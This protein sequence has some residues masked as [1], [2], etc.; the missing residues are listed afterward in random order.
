MDSSFP[1]SSRL[2]LVRTVAVLSALAML[3]LSPTGA[4]A[5][6]PCL[7][8]LAPNE[9]LCSPAV[10]DSGW[11]I[12]HRGP[13]AQGSSALPG[14]VAGQG[15]TAEHIDLTGT[16][17]TLAASPE[18]GDG[19]H[20][21]WGALLGLNG[22]II[23][24]DGA[25][26]S[27]VDTYIPEDEELD[28]PTIPL[29]VSGAYNVVDPSFNFVLGR[30]DFVEIYGD[31][32]P[33]DRSSEIALI[34]RVFLPPSFFCR[35]TDILVGGVMLPDGNLALVTEQAA[36]GVIPS[37]EIGMDVANLVSLP[38]ENGADCAD[39]LIPDEDLETVSNSIAADESGGIYVVS[40][41]AMYKYQWDGT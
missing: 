3:V 2:F 30:A 14:P 17:I 29:G 27:L 35:D 22:G 7:T 4:R 36:V 5:Q 25:T 37:D 31:S 32:T 1:H 41:A 38:S 11:P 6:D 18:Y 39:L 26:F 12:S 23:K 40:D 10:S 13:Y 21:I 19:E 24:I 34:K 33:G 15:I 16:P 9:P 20:A 8:P 28:P